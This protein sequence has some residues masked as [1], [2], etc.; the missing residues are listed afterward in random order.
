MCWEIAQ[1]DPQLRTRF[2]PTDLYPPFLFLTHSRPLRSNGG[3]SLIS[4]D[5]RIVCNNT[6][7]DRLKIS[8]NAN[9]PTIRTKL[10]E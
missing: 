3:I 1:G 6:L 10:F 2:Q 5:G 4:G 7:D 8:Y 9:L